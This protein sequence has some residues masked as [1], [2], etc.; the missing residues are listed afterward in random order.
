M[1]GDRTI[2]MLWFRA[3]EFM[4]HGLEFCCFLPP[5]TFSLTAKNK[6]ILFMTL[7]Q[8]ALCVLTI[9]GKF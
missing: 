3:L 1:F 6:L 9:P 2:H 8:E 4:G 7:A 5:L